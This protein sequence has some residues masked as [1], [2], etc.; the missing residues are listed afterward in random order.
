M[1]QE[2]VVANYTVL[3]NKTNGSIITAFLQMVEI[4]DEYLETEDIKR[5]FVLVFKPSAKNISLI[6]F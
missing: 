3:S 6:C 1:A 2:K 4:T 5:F